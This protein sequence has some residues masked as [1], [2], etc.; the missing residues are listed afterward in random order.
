MKAPSQL[1]QYST[2]EEKKQLN[3][4]VCVLFEAT[5]N[6]KNERAKGLIQIHLIQQGEKNKQLNPNV[7]VLFKTTLNTHT[8][9][10]PKLNVL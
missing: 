3:P 9:S 4:K 1:F 2:I 8:F 6:T 10:L 5:F 7:C